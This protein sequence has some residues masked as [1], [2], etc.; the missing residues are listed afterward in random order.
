MILLSR[1]YHVL[2]CFYIYYYTLEL[3]LFNNINTKLL[4]L[5]L[6]NVDRPVVFKKVQFSNED[7][8]IKNNISISIISN[9]LKEF[10]INENK[11]EEY[12]GNNSTNKDNNNSFDNIL[13]TKY[14]YKHNYNTTFDNNIRKLDE[15]IIEKDYKCGDIFKPS[16]E[17]LLIEEINNT[18]TDLMIKSKNDSIPVREE[19]Y[20]Q[21]ENSINIVDSFTKKNNE[22]NYIIKN[23]TT[24]IL[25]NSENLETEGIEENDI[26]E[27]N[28][29]CNINT[30]SLLLDL[31]NQILPPEILD[32][33]YFNSNHYNINY[34]KVISTLQQNIFKLLNSDYSNNIYNSQYYNNI[35]SINSINSINN[36]INK[37]INNIDFI[38]RTNNLLKKKNNIYFNN[39]NNMNKE[40]NCNIITNA[41]NND[42][43]L[44][45][46]EYKEKIFY[47]HQQP[48]VSSNSLI[49]D[50]KNRSS[51][52]NNTGKYNIT[53]I[54]KINKSTTSTKLRRLGVK[55][56]DHIEILPYERSLL[57]KSYN[58]ITSIISFQLLLFFM[59]YYTYCLSSFIL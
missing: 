24:K 50:S 8:I 34:Y 38:N 35:N 58:I 25:R 56:K 14:Q 48:L 46:E 6:Y 4:S 2:L 26:E 29:N 13:T 7:T 5:L 59:F 30:H 44:L 18:N 32:F 47:K 9:D 45:E 16:Q 22:I 28:N 43:L 12:K 10:E 21:L 42:L 54:S 55:K 3:G 51:S 20:S 1:Y 39:N 17:D 49:S 53:K 57:S 52:I 40:N 37:N 41:N 15:M 11:E 36:S 33:N 31:L 27:D 23:N 19:K